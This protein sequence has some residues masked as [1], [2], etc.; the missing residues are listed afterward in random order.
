MLDTFI[1]EE[2]RRREKEEQARVERPRLELPLYDEPPSD[3]EEDNDKRRPTG[4][5]IVID[6]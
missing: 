5:V 1:I 6:L 3:G 4:N 2:L